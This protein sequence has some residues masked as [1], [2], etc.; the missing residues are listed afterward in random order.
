MSLR[1]TD[2]KITVNVGGSSSLRAF[3]HNGG[4]DNWKTIVTQD[5]SGYSVLSYGYSYREQQ[6]DQNKA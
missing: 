6:A 3:H 5:G 4:T 1:C 2:T